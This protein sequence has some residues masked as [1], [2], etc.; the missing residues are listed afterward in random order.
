VTTD[1]HH[2]C[3]VY[4][5]DLPLENAAFIAASRADIPYLLTALAEAEAREKRL[6]E[7]LRR[8]GRHQFPS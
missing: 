6:R 4:A 1:R 3:F 5:E 2:I 7:A 8:Y